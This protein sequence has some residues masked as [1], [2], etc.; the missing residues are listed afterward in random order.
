MRFV[1]TTPPF[2]LFREGYGSKRRIKKGHIPPLGVGY[3]AS[4]AL[5][6]GIDTYIVDP[7][8]LSLDF[9]KTADLIAGYKPDVIGI[10]AM[11]ANEEAVSGS[12]Y[13]NA[14]MN[15]EVDRLLVL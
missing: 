11:T 3:I 6:R 8:V 10:S 9:E 4:A 5:K 1:L 13:D 12:Q 7:S 14:V 15:R 2:D